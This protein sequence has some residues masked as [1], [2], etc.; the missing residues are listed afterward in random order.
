MICKRIAR[1]VLFLTLVGC[2]STPKLDTTNDPAYEK[3]FKVMVKALS[4]EEQ[5]KLNVDLGVIATAAQ[6]A[7]N[8][9]DPAKGMGGVIAASMSPSIRYKDANGLTAEQI[10]DKAIKIRNNLNKRN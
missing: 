2:D 1:I 3:S 7:K 6:N 5:R 4:K 9:P 10:H 8:K